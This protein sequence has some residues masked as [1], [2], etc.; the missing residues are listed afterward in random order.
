M[1][2]MVNP[3]NYNNKVKITNMNSNYNSFIN[4]INHSF[5]FSF[6]L[7]TCCLKEYKFILYLHLAIK[8][9]LCFNRLPG[10]KYNI[11]C[12]FSFRHKLHLPSKQLGVVDLFNIFHLIFE[13]KP[14]FFNF[15]KCLHKAVWFL[16]RL[17]ENEWMWLR[18][19]NFHLT[20]Q[21]P[22]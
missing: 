16:K 12:I 13:V 20:N 5:S 8:P 15:Q 6:Y 19:P 17:W 11:I 7:F 2:I 10:S 4:L 22:K 14:I 18:Y 3:T 9:H 1:L 21:I